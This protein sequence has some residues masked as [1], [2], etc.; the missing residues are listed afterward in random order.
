MGE[1]PM[2]VE[3]TSVQFVEMRVLSWRRENTQCRLEDVRI[4]RGDL[5]RWEY[6]IQTSRGENTQLRSSLEGLGN[7]IVKS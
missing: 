5:E 6:S 1:G 2:K 4:L 3:N 7:N